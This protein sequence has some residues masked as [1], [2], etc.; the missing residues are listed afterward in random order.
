MPVN[1]RAGADELAQARRR[2]DG[3]R[4]EVSGDPR[5]VVQG[6]TAS[7][8]SYRDAGEVLGVSHQRVAQ[9]VAARG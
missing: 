6:L 7:G 1:A 2:L 9:L 8:L 3:A 5:Q 4:Q